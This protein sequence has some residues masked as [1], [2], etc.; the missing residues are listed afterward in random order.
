MLI[1]SPGGNRCSHLLPGLT[2]S[3]TLWS[4]LFLFSEKETEAQRG[5]ITQPSSLSWHRAGMAFA[6]KNL[7]PS[8]HPFTV[9]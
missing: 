3:V 8:V 4:V 7:F 5:A 6:H 2:G 1:V 9:C